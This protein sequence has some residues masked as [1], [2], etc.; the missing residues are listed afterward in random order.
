MT[1]NVMSFCE[2]VQK[3]CNQSY[4]SRSFV[5]KDKKSKFQARNFSFWSCL[6]YY[7]ESQKIHVLDTLFNSYSRIA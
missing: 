3:E 6:D 4:I 5:T 1:A 7:Q 2:G